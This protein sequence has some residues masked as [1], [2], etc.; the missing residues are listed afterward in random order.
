[1]DS[2]RPP[3]RACLAAIA[4]CLACIAP[5][6]QAGPRVSTHVWPALVL[7]AWDRPEDLRQLDAGAGVAFLA[8][9]IT[10]SGSWLSVEPRRHPLRVSPDTVIIAV[11]R[12]ESDVERTAALAGPTLDALAVAI[13]DTAA[14]PGVSGV[15]IDFDARQTERGTYRELLGRVR[16]QLPS[17]IPLAI[18]ALASWCTGDPWLRG[19]PVDE[20]IPMLFRMGPGDAPYERI[21][22]SPGDARP[23]CRQAVGVSLDEPIALRPR[24]RRIY[25]FSPR[26]WT[27]RTIAEG[28]RWASG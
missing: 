10:I 28:A 16:R 14:L 4:V 23:E 12:I 7:W 13:A 11:T 27:A 18:T 1:M 9:T 8:Q 6:G 17:G 24:G 20:A 19:V 2:D 25:L 5:A 15:Q 3:R 21:G 26:P 22:S